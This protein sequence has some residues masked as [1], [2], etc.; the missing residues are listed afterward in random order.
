MLNAAIKAKV[1]LFMPSEYTLD[2]THPAA[3]QI[4]A[5]I[6][7]GERATWADK[8]SEIAA[9]GAIDYTTLVVGGFLDLGLKSGFMGFD[10]A[11]HQAKLYDDGAHKTTGSTL[12]FI[13]QA[14]VTV[15][16]IPRD[17]TRNRRIHAVEV[18]Y[19]GQEL[20]AAFEQETGR[21][22]TVERISTDELKDRFRRALAEGNKR[23]AYLSLVMGLNFDGSGAA[24]LTSGLTFGE[25]FGLRRRSL[26]DVV[27]QVVDESKRSD[28]KGA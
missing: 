16:Q 25:D 15:L 14:V 6:L 20:L 19:S 13:A 8:I 1:K 23:A 3:R 4:G 5:E 27:R 11:N 10:I 28:A 17:R 18:E 22:W 9:S 2:V 7:N 24:N 21:K 26:A 12:A